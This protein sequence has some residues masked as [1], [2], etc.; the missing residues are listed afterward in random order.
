MKWHL[1]SRD[2]HVYFSSSVP[3]F[4]ATFCDRLWPRDQTNQLGT[5]QPCLPLISASVSLLF[6]DLASYAGKAYYFDCGNNLF[7]FF[8]NSRLIKWIQQ[9]KNYKKI[10][11]L[12]RD[13]VQI[14]CL[15]IRHSN[16]YTRMF[17]VLVWGCNLSNSSNLSNWKKISSFKKKKLD[18]T[19]SSACNEWKDAKGTACCLC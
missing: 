2:L 9:N 16:H 12:T 4:V 14:A 15:A 3:P 13:W 7:E 6:T 1:Q 18:Y 19:P 11:R 17:S 10:Q 5:K 8:H